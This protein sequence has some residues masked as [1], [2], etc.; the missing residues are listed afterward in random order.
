M[1]FHRRHWW[2]NGSGA[3]RNT[4]QGSGQREDTEEAQATLLPRQAALCTCTTVRLR[5]AVTLCFLNV[6][7]YNAKERDSK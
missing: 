2:Q 5:K 6:C 1:Y 7:N 4:D 3:D